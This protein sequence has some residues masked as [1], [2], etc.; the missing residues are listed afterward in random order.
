[1]FCQIAR[2]MTG[3]LENGRTTEAPMRNQQRSTGSHLGAG[4]HGLDVRHQAH[5]RLQLLI[6]NLK[7]EQGGHGSLYLMA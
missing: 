6:V 3:E 4:N 5:Q 7:G 2:G 1:M